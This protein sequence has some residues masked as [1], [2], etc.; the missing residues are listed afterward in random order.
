MRPRTNQGPDALPIAFCE[1]VDQP[2]AMDTWEPRR[3]RLQRPAATTLANHTYRA[4]FRFPGSIAPYSLSLK[5]P[6]QCAATLNVS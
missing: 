2:N 3:A 4:S 1:A 5:A 6:P